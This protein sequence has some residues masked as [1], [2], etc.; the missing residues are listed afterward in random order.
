MSTN[1]QSIL[2]AALA[3]AEEERAVIAERLLASL[4][5]DDGDLSPDEMLA[6]LDG[7]LAE[8][9]RDPSTAVPWSELKDES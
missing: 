8:F 5:P 1:S 9:E 7:R 2:D 3:L 4:S 6:E